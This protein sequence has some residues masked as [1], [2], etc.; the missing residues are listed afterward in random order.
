[1]KTVHFMLFLL[2]VVFLAGCDFTIITNIINPEGGGG[3]IKTSTEGTD[4]LTLKFFEGAPPESLL[5]NVGSDSE[6]ETKVNI[7]IMIENRG[8]QDLNCSKQE[9][10]GYFRIDGGKYIKLDETFKAGTLKQALESGKGGTVIPGKIWYGSGGRVAI[11]MQASLENPEKTT[12]ST[13]FAN[14]CYPYKTSLSTPICV[15]TAH[16]S[17]ENRVCDLRALSF[18]SQGAPVAITR[19]DQDSVI[20]GDEVKPRLGIHVRNVG[21][22]FVIG[23]EDEELKGACT[24]GGDSTEII[25][26]IT[27][28]SASLSGKKFDCVNKEVFLHGGVGFFYC[29]LEVLEGEGFGRNAA[30]NLVSPFSITLAYGYRNAESKTVN[31]EVLD[32][33]PQVTRVSSS[34]TTIEGNGETFEITVTA[35][36]DNRIEN[37]SIE[38]PGMLSSK[39][40]FKCSAQRCTAKF[41]VSGVS[42]KTGS[43]ISY[44]VKAA[45][46]QRGTS[47]PKK[48]LIK[49]GFCDK[50][51]IPGELDTPDKEYSCKDSTTCSSD[52]DDDENF[53]WRPDN[54]GYECRNEYDIC[55]V[56]EPIASGPI[57]TAP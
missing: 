2:A 22:G 41:V 44:T 50:L 39:G 42:G 45:D 15:E 20:D 37:I 31:I 12:R 11:E 53:R 17:V 33:K 14:V 8:V 48:V 55:C 3:S 32:E 47:E 27:V 25:G 13:I 51:N 49:V 36:D 19:I 46:N 5:A 43:I 10:C 1:M 24:A 16:Y 6:I 52:S 38:G 57:E 7:G 54:R 21:S 23:K 40:V 35:I 28:E 18:S 26:K 29:V 56:K 30:N 4:G 9:E 34:K